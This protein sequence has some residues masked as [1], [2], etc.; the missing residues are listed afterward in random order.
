MPDD[1]TQIRLSGRGGQGIML[2]GVIVA[3]AAML[4][5]M[6]VVQ[7]QSYGPEA[8]L[9]AAR[10]EIV[11]SRSPI[12]FPEVV[13]ADIV[14]CLSKDAYVKH[15]KPLA[16]HGLRLVDER[17]TTELPVPDGIVLPLVD[18][19][20]SLGSILSANM[21]ALGA[22]VAL[23]GVLPEESV[24]RAIGGRVKRGTLESN[25]KAFDAGLALGAGARAPVAAA[26]R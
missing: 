16:P 5:G 17:V 21:V 3:E 24:R 15:G 19:A 7:T 9:G 4:D 1:V 2:A 20:Q 11:V 14:L 8:R 26:G 6:H 12:A 18:A 25:L 10:A 22:L 23:T 13:R